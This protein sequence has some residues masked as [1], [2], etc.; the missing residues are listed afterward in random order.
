MANRERVQLLLLTFLNLTNEVLALK[1]FMC[2]TLD[3]DKS[4]PFPDADPKVWADNHAKY[5]T[6]PDT[7][8]VVAFESMSG[9]VHLQV[10]NHRTKLRLSPQNPGCQRGKQLQFPE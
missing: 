9:R 5:F 10:K 2:A 4:C 8:C 3:L 1:C 6:V 7:R